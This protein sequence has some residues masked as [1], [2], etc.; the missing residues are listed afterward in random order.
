MAQ[1]VLDLIEPGMSAMFN[2]GSMAALLGATL[3]AKR[4]LTVITNNAA[5][6]DKLRGEAGITLIALAA[7]I[8]Q[9]SMVFSAW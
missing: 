6:I 8:M 1:L 5:I 4:P 3:I 2:D 9:S 7:Y